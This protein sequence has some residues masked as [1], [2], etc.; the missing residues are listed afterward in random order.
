MHQVSVWMY[1]YIAHY[2]T[3]YEHLENTI[4]ISAGRNLLSFCYIHHLAHF[5]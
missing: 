5:E 1:M 2:K 4:A 3:G